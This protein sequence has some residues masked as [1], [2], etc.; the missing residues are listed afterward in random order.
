[1]S[2]AQRPYGVFRIGPYRR[3]RPPAAGRRGD[4]RSLASTAGDNPAGLAA[5][6]HLTRWVCNHPLNPRPLSGPEGDRHDL[7]GPGL[8]I[9]HPEAV[10]VRLAVTD[11]AH[12]TGSAS[13]AVVPSL[14]QQGGPFWVASDRW[15]RPA[16]P[17]HTAPRGL[18]EVGRAAEPADPRHPRSWGRVS[19]RGSPAAAP[20]GHREQASLCKPARMREVDEQGSSEHATCG[21]ERL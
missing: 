12:P 13:P 18:V 6:Q 21:C 3:S 17:G 5:W 14:W 11:D 1:M 15:A 20:P 2:P 19:P 9:P 10:D 16:P 4:R 8:V 7:V